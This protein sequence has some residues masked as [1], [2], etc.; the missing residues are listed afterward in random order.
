MKLCRVCGKLATWFY[1]PG[2]DNDCYCDDCVPRGCTCNQHDLS[3]EFDGV[4]FEEF[5]KGQEGV[6]WQ[7]IEKDKVW[8]NL[9][10]NRRKLPC[11]EYWYFEE[12]IEKEDDNDD[13]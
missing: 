10:G 1:M 12:G 6:D 4:K 13:N 3:A 11:C 5:P 2:D 8:E 9:D 7:W